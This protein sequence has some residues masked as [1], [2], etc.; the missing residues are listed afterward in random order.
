[1]TSLGVVILKNILNIYIFKYINILF[2]R[3]MNFKRL[4]SILP[5]FNYMRT[6]EVQF[7]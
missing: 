7:P 4:G 5:S 1:M 2:F 3:K 6:A